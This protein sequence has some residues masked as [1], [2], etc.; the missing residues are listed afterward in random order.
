[1]SKGHY[2]GLCKGRHTLPTAVTEYIYPTEVNPLDVQGL[3]KQALH[4]LRVNADCERPHLTLYATGLSV[5][6]CAVI[7]ACS[8]A[9][10]SI[11]IMHY[12]RDDNSYYPQEIPFYEEW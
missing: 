8:E 2:I 3:R 6:L 5:A 1:M 7:A 12:N 11:T 10:W 9:R 4:W